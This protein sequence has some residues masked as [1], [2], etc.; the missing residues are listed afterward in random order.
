MRSYESNLA[1]MRAY[2]EKKKQERLDPPLSPMDRLKS[3]GYAA[4]YI[5]GLELVLKTISDR[6]A[7]IQVVPQLKDEPGWLDGKKDATRFASEQ[8]Q[9]YPPE[10]VAITLDLKLQQARATFQTIMR[11]LDIRKSQVVF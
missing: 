9:V 2:N 6:Y 4:G 1:Y 8:L 11:S 7:G 5:Y 3:G 10:A